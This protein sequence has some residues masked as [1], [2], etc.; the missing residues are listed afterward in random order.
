[1]RCGG[2]KKY[3]FP[4]QYRGGRECNKEWAE[5]VGLFVEVESKE[6]LIEIKVD[7]IIYNARST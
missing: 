1:M 3:V 2:Q 6:R 5:V 4:R 7:L